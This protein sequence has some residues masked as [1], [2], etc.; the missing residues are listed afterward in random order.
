MLSNG[1]CSPDCIIKILCSA[2]YLFLAFISS[3]KGTQYTP[4][5]PQSQALFMFHLVLTWTQAQLKLL[6]QSRHKHS[7]LNLSKCLP[8]TGPWAKRKRKEHRVWNLAFFCRWKS[9]RIKLIWFLPCFRIS[10]H[11]KNANIYRG[12]PGKK[13]TSNVF[14]FGG[15]SCSAWYWR[16]KSQTFLERLSKELKVS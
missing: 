16:M 8:N 14:V 4:F 5:R 13:V 3:P 7:S 10:V 6:Q 12:S 9:I 1:I 15:N 2:P 11:Y